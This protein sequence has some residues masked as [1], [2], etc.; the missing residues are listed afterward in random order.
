MQGEWRLWDKLAAMGRRAG[1][2]QG[3][4][5]PGV[6]CQGDDGTG[7]MVFWWPGGKPGWKCVMAFSLGCAPG[8]K[9]EEKDRCGHTG[10]GGMGQSHVEVRGA[11][12]E[13]RSLK[14]VLGVEAR[15]RSEVG[16][17]EREHLRP[18]GVFAH[19]QADSSGLL[20]PIFLFL[21]GHG[22][23]SLWHTQEAEA[24]VSP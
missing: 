5:P 9:S 1:P 16:R 8:K 2:G 20:F 15:T 3:S 19:L 21:A 14:F 7:G 13:W 18:L 22:G 10:G 11:T 17:R 12:W 4:Q 23:S 24:G 6:R